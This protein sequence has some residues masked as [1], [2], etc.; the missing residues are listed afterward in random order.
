LAVIA[1]ARFQSQAN[2]CEIFGEKEVLG[3]DFSWFFNF[4]QSVSLKKS[5]LL[6]LLLSVIHASF[7]KGEKLDL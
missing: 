4:A 2:P 5:R 6:A 7:L 3:Q 1:E